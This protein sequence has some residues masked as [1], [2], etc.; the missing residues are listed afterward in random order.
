MTQHNLTTLTD[1][2]LILKREQVQ[3][4]FYDNL[5]HYPRY[6][7]EKHQEL[8]RIWQEEVRRGI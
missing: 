3:H 6:Y 5:E 1:E 4:C 7:E 2:Q 8:K